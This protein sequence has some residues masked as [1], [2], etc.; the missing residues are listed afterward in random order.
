M[1]LKKILA[2]GL[3]ALTIGGCGAE[4]MKKQD[5]S[6]QIS[7]D[8]AKAT[9]V[10]YRSTSYGWAKEIYNYIDKTFIGA[11]KGKCYFVSKLE[12][13]DHYLIAD[14]ENKACAKINVEAGKVY[15]VQQNIFMGVMSAR[16]GFQGSNPQDFDGQKKELTYVILNPEEKAP[17][18]EEKDYNETVKDFEKENKEDPKKHEDTN[19]LKGY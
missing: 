15:F 3:L 7:A 11:T 4:Y 1:S 18:L 19:N 5:T 8:P 17:T 10:I 2:I 6:P 16:T 9:L 14:A 12:P 13:G